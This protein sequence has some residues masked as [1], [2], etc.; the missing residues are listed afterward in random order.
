M[1][2]TTQEIEALKKITSPSVANAIETFNVRP[3]NQGQ[4]S[5]EIRTLFPDLL[6]S[7]RV[8]AV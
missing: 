4:M 1:P 2:L 3:R 5:S 7:A 6:P 8:R